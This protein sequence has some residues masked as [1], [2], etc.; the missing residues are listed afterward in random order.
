[1]LA[2]P[3]PAGNGPGA[4]WT[5]LPTAIASEIAGAI[6]TYNGS[7]NNPLFGT[8]Y[9]GCELVV[10]VGSATFEPQ[11]AACLQV[12]HPF[13]PFNALTYVLR[14]RS[15]LTQGH[16]QRRSLSAA[17]SQAERRSSLRSSCRRRSAAAYN[18]SGV[19]LFSQSGTFG[20]TFAT[21]DTAPDATGPDTTGLDSDRSRR[22]RRWTVRSSR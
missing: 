4:H 11:L 10:P 14:Q 5:E 2:S 6:Q 3:T 15:L 12:C 20:A 21:T 1:M 19:L 22:P 9:T 7:Y 16:S 8:H 18:Y 17:L 13:C